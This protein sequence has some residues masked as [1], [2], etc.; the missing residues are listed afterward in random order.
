[1]V[2]GLCQSLA[3]PHRSPSRDCFSFRAISWIMDEEDRV[4]D[5][6]PSRK[7]ISG[8]KVAGTST[9]RRGVSN[10]R[11]IDWEMSCLPTEVVGQTRKEVPCARSS[12][13]NARFVRTVTIR[14]PRT[15]RPRRVVWSS[16]SSA[17]PAGSTRT[18]KRPSR[19]GRA[20]GVICLTAGRGELP[21]HRGV[22]STVK[23]SVSKTE[24][25]GSNPSAPASI[26]HSV[27]GTSDGLRISGEV[28]SLGTT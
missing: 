6:S 23:L 1:M 8:I 5:R 3:T 27:G 15:R 2:A 7:T 24:L 17:I 9:L 19:T 10:G 18:T 21:H 16:R 28:S 25:L 12:H 14:R 11:K 22:S 26:L 4:P 13:C 20:G